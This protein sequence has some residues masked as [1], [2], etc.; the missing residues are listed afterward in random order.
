MSHWFCVA[1]GLTKRKDEMSLKP[2]NHRGLCKAHYNIGVRM[3]DYESSSS[4]QQQQQQQQQHAPIFE[5]SS[6]HHRI[7]VAQRYAII[8]LHLLDYT[9]ENIASLINVHIKS[10]RR[11][12]HHFEISEEFNEEAVSDFHREGKLMQT[13]PNIKSLYNIQNATHDVFDS[14]TL[15][16]R[17]FCCI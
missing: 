1:C 3:S 8:T 12:I 4:E 14:N 6:E 2:Q 16:Y 15:Y 7:S 9:H 10:V 11:W 13:K 5:K 17:N